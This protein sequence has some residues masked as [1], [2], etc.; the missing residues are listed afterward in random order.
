MGYQSGEESAEDFYKH[1]EELMKGIA[2]TESQGYCYTQLTDVQQE[3]NG[4]LSADH[5]P[6]FEIERLKSLFEIGKKKC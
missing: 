3:V 5:T 6:K 2:E 1:L 4:L